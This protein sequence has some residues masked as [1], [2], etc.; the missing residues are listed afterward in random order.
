M[1][2]SNPTKEDIFKLFPIVNNEPAY[3]IYFN[4]FIYGRALDKLSTNDVIDFCEEV[5][6]YDI[7]GKWVAIAIIS[8]YCHNDQKL[9]KKC[10]PFIKQLVVSDNFLNS[11]DKVRTMDEY[12]WSNSIIRI[13][14]EER[15]EQFAEEISKQIFEA[16]EEL[17]TSSVDG[18]LQNLC[19]ELIAEY[20]ELFWSVLS[21]G[22]HG[23]AYLNIKFTLG[24][25]NGSWGEKGLLFKGDND[26]IYEWCKSNKPTGALR[27]AYMMPIYENLEGK[28]LWHPFALKMINEFGS[29][30]GFLQE[31]G[32]NMGS[33][34]SVGSS[35][36]YYKMQIELVKELF[37]HE[38]FTVREWA[39]EKLKVLEKTILRETIDEESRGY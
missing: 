38:N 8:Q 7:Q 31:L 39:K 27:I 6:K 3:V 16:F 2:V 17:R 4:N 35:I 15:D 13:L 37:D 11:F 30:D 12:N 18:Y 26:L 20:F 24:S 14:K 34:S 9:W 22:I 25:H 32:A 5:A 28:P 21:K 36:G 10:K 19:S 1:R 33:F 29:D 23:A